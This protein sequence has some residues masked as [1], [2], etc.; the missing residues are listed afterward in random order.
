MEYSDNYSCNKLQWKMSIVCTQNHI[1][2]DGKACEENK[3]GKHDL[4]IREI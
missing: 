1:D 4:N 3:E 2:F